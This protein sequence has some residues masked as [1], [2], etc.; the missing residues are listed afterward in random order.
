MKEKRKKEPL[1]HWKFCYIYMLMCPSRELFTWLIRYGS[2]HPIDLVQ[3]ERGA[4]TL[5]PTM[6]GELASLLL[7]FLCLFHAK[8][9]SQTVEREKTV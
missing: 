7:L 1:R 6:H 4:K 3:G 2:L 8:A 5:F 9:K